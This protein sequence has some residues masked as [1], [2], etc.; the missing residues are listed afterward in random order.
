MPV[1][2]CNLPSPVCPGIV[3]TTLSSAA[4]SVTYSTATTVVSAA[5]FVPRLDVMPLESSCKR[6]RE[7][8]SS[9][10][11]RLEMLAAFEEVWAYGP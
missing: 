5:L 7:D 1:S 3:I 8:S 9:S 2:L 6:R 11:Y 4:C 10:V